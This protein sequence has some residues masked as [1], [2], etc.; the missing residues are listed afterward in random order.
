MENKIDGR[1]LN[2]TGLSRIWSK[3]IDVECLGI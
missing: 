1:R 3:S 2:E